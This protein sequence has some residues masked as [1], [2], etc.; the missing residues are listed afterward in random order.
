VPDGASATSEPEF[1]ESD[2]DG[3]LEASD[4]DP[5]EQRLEER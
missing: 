1:A 5:L 2:G 3:A 4:S